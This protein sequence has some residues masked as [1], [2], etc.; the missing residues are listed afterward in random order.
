MIA[1]AG[2]ER[3]RHMSEDDINKHFK[4]LKFGVKPRWRLKEAAADI[5]S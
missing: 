2:L 5:I 3:M 1:T 4:N